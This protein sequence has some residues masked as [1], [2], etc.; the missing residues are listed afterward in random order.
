MR[1]RLLHALPAALIALLSAGCATAQVATADAL[2]GCWFFD[3]TAA[4]ERLNL[5]WGIELRTDSV[6]GW[7]AI[8]QLPDVRRAVTLADRERTADFPFGYWRTF[9]SDSI[10]IGY[11]AGGG[12]VLALTVQ[13]PLADAAFA[14]RLEGTA[15]A[16]GDARPI[17][18]P[19][20]RP[21][22]TDA[23]ALT[24]ATCP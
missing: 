11:P 20:D 5:P 7:P 6:Q 24:R 12:L 14:A 17:D 8:A 16:V 13:P 22:Q 2:A 15:R 10:E 3:R 21:P 18:Q 4:A 19:F 23:V 9:A 1:R